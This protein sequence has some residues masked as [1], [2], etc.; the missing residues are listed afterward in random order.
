[1]PLLDQTQKQIAPTALAIQSVDDNAGV[2]EVGSHLPPGGPVQPLFAFIAEFLHPPS[3][4]AFEFRVVLILPSRSHTLQRLDLLKPAK[5][6]FSSL[7]E[8]LAASALANQSVNLAH[9]RFGDD[10]VCAS[11]AH[12]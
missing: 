10:D 12:S 11:I 6:L 1:M 9:E 8:K 7:G 2:N 4:S 3:G 5:L